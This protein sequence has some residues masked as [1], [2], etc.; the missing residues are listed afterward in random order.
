M[1]KLF[2]ALVAA[3]TCLACFAAGASAKPAPTKLSIQAYPEGVYGYVSSPAAK[4]CAD[5]RRVIVFEQAGSKRDPG[6]DP[7]V[8]S[9][10]AGTGEGSDQWSAQ[11]SRSGPFYAQVAA[12]PGCGSAL[13]DAVEPL[14]P[15]LGAGAET[16]TYPPC[17]PYVSEGS[18]Q[19][20]RFEEAHYDLELPGVTPCRFGNSSGNCFGKGS[21][22]LFPW[23]K[24][25]DG[26]EPPV[27]VYWRPA[28][29]VRSLEFVTF[30]GDRPEGA[31][32]AHLGGTIPGDDSDKFTVTDGFAQSEAGAGLGDHFKTLDLPGQRP[33]EVGGPLDLNFVNSGGGGADAY[34]YGYLSVER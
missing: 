8:A 21:G 10:I 18:S 9:D 24:K 30:G 32:I 16:T 26:G 31:G 13:S 7:R 15:L 4:T 3:L 17:G 1:R 20:C 33:G 27:R 11:T 14:S 5:K 29:D 12:K 25:G 22:G 23:S 34:I 2:V 19:Y 6:S 28:G